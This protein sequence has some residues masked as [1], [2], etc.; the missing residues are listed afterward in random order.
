MKI[1][2][3]EKLIKRNAKIGQYSSLAGLL[4]II[5]TMVFL[6]QFIRTPESATQMNTFILWGIL[7]LGIALSQVSMY[8]G[9][10]WGRRPDEALDKALKGLPGDS[11]LYHYSSPVPHLLVGAAGIWI[12][13]PYHLRGTV[14]YRKNRWR[15]GGGG[16]TQGYLRIFGQETIG[17]PDLEFSGQA[18][19][20]EKHLKKNFEE[21]QE[22]PPIRGALVFLDNKV[23]IA[24][25]DPPLP[26]MQ[27]AKLKD[28]LRKASKDSPLSPAELSRVKDALP[29]E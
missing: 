26:A 27:V 4:I 20:L 15:V 12:L 3:N 28:F 29:A 6:F 9:T 23:E 19:A 11:T 10:R 8:F 24:A 25:D 14:T 1:I 7:F 13:L 22:I 2:K 16:F 5:G 18:A 17:R 21:G